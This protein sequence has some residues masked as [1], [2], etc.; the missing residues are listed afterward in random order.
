MWAMTLGEFLP[1]QLRDTALVGC[2]AGILWWLIGNRS[3]QHR[4]RATVTAPIAVGSY[5]AAGF[6][7]WATCPNV[8]G[9]TIAFYSLNGLMAG[10]VSGYLI[11]WWVW[12]YYHRENEG[13]ED[14]R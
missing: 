3:V 13:D 14:A 5:F 10:V 11:S 8:T 1:E 2:I 9:P 6:L 4:F 7:A 12:K